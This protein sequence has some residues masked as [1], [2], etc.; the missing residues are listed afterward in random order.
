MVVYTRKKDER[1]AL[2]GPE[3]EQRDKM[4]SE[5]PAV[6]G[7][8]LN[9]QGW[10]WWLKLAISA[11]TEE[12]GGRKAVELVQTRLQSESP[13]QETITIF[14]KNGNLNLK[15]NYEKT[16][17]KHLSLQERKSNTYRHFFTYNFL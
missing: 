8:N 4:R 2:E 6:H 12:A 14:F 17:Q 9:I 3:I 16:N 7:L 10:L 15:D 11:K 5:E 1:Q 13:S